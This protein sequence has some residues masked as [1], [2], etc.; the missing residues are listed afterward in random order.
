MFLGYHI[1]NWVKTWSEI[2][3]AASWAHN[4]LPPYDW[5]PE[6]VKVG[7]VDFP[8]AQNFHRSIFRSRWYKLL[9]YMAGYIALNARSTFWSKWISTR[10]Q[11]KDAKTTGLAEGYAIGVK[12][13]N[14]KDDQH[15]AGSN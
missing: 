9:V 10:T 11:I 13:G 5:D 12:D 6:F 3:F 8:S 14:G 4:F 15:D 1:P 2:T 7:L